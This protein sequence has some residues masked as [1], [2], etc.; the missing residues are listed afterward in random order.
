VTQGGSYLGGDVFLPPASWLGTDPVRRPDGIGSAGTG[1]GGAFLF[2]WKSGDA[3]ARVPPK[4]FV[5]SL[6]RNGR[7]FWTT[8]GRGGP[9]LAGERIPSGVVETVRHETAACLPSQ[10][11]AIM[12]SR[13]DFI[14]VLGRLEYHRMQWRIRPG[15]HT[16]VYTSTCS[17][18]VPEYGKIP[19]GA[20]FLPLTRRR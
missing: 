11:M 2:I 9:L 12:R 8:S 13:I 5:E 10:Q 20:S 17:T 14:A 3:N 4:D 1:C 19:Y 6:A 7:I 16:G 15:R 18:S